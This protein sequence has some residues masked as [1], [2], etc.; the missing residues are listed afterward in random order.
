M[1][2]MFF[3]ASTLAAIAFATPAMAQDD[4]DQSFT[5][6]RAEAIVGWDRIEDGSNGGGKDGV[7]YGGALGYDYQAGKIVLG[8]EGEITGASTRDQATSIIVPGDSFR[9]K[10]GRDLYAGARVGVAVSPRAMIYAKGGYTNAGVNTRYV[11]GATTVDTSDDLDGWRA[12]AGVELKLGGK[13]YAKGEYRY[14]H[15]GDIK[16]TSIDLDRHQV[17]GGIGIRF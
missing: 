4:P 17:V 9:V 7:V 2:T 13:V 16:G 11:N 1:R 14:S 15:Y 10:A 12:G 3:A 8:A 5:G 6:P